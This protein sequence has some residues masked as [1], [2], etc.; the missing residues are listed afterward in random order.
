MVEATV[1]G[2]GWRCYARNQRS[3]L[4]FFSDHF[5]AIV[6]NFHPFATH[7]VDVVNP[8]SRGLPGSATMSLL[9]G[10][11]CRRE[12]WLR[13]NDCFSARQG[14]CISMQD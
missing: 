2:A 13:Q 4:S 14:Q 5:L 9:N 12:D 10:I 3:G 11:D 8:L 7:S 1:R 6:T